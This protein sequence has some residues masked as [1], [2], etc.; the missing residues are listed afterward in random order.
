MT[1]YYSIYER[2]IEVL[3]CDRYIRYCKYNE[4]TRTYFLP[5]G[6]CTRCLNAIYNRTMMSVYIRY[7]FVNQGLGFLVWVYMYREGGVTIYTSQKR[8]G[9]R[10]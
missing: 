4:I 5:F 10:V 1:C 3:K 2:C 8:W 7:V 6:S 9:L